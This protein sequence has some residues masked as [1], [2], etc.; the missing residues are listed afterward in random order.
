MKHETWR[1]GTW[2]ESEVVK[3]RNG[4]KPGEGQIEKAKRSYILGKG[5]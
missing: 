1:Q 4:N 5:R 3:Q 2:N